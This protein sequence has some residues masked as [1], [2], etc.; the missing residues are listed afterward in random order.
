MGSFTGWRKASY[1]V[2]DGNCV[3]AAAGQQAVGV[4]DTT[5][6]GHGPVLEFTTGSW[7]DFL[8]SIRA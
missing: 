1:S 5:L 2:P 7:R 8:A 6:A 3:E 4:R